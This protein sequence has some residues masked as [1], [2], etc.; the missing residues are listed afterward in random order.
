MYRRC[1][2][3]EHRKPPQ[4]EPIRA[5]ARHVI[6]DDARDTAAAIERRIGASDCGESR[7]STSGRA[8]PRSHACTGMLKPCLRAPATS[9]PYCAPRE[10]AQHALGLAAGATP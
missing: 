3:D 4:L 5:P 1:Q 7:S 8:G 2:A 6:G 9:T 10:L